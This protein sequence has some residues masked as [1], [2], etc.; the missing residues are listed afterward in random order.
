[1]LL[2]DKY[3]DSYLT[4]TKKKVIN[5]HIHRS[6]RMHKHTNRL[7]HIATNRQ[8]QRQS[9]EE[10]TIQTGLQRHLPTNSHKD[11]DTNWQIRRQLQRTNTKSIT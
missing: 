6:K 7:T 4:D 3:K 2:P 9:Y 1:M 11:R 10:I 5:R 8:M